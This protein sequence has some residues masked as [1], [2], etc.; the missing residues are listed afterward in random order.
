MDIRIKWHLKGLVENLL[1]H[2]AS[3]M[4]VLDCAPPSL[5]V[6]WQISHG[7]LKFI[8]D[9]KLITVPAQSLHRLINLYTLTYNAILRPYYL[10]TFISKLLSA[11]TRVV[12]V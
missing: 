8:S 11:V 4:P 1:F 12:V 6:L 9:C 7:T 3:V 5:F 10:C 2:T